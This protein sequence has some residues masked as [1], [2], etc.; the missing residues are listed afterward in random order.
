L[1]GMHEALGFISSITKQ[2]RMSVEQS[3]SGGSRGG[4]L[5]A[6]FPVE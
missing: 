6:G 3:V 1:L 4:S 2:S 5:A